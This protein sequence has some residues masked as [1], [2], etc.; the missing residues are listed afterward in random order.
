MEIIYV[1][2]T[3]ILRME[4]IVDNNTGE[5]IRV[6]YLDIQ[7]YVQQDQLNDGVYPNQDCNIN[8]ARGCNAKKV[9]LY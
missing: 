8:M 1:K 3:L 5:G 7:S 2:R 9:L 6:S 4:K